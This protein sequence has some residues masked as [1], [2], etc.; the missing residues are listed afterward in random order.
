MVSKAV[1]S[2]PY[3]GMLTQC[4][5]VKLDRVWRGFQLPLIRGLLK[6]YCN[7]RNAIVYF[8]RARLH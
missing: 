3:I 2:V 6:L 4:L 5:C 1:Y 7:A 8:E